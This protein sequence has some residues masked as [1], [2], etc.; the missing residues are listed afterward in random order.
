MPSKA[1]KYKQFTVILVSRLFLKVYGHISMKYIRMHEAK[2][3]IMNFSNVLY[4]VVRRERGDY[5]SQY[6]TCSIVVKAPWV[7]IETYRFPIRIK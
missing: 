7:R 3:K 6:R 1:C 4:F 5:V 2:H